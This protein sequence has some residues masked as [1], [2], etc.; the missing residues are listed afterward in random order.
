L[1]VNA[2]R[3]PGRGAGTSPA[4][5][6]AFA[7]RPRL[8]RLRD[9]LAGYRPPRNRWGEPAVF[10]FDPSRQAELD[11]AR[12]RDPKPPSDVTEL[13]AAELPHLLASVEVRRVAR[14][15]RGLREAAAT[16]VARLPVAKDLADLL[17][18]PDDETVL[19]LDPARRAGLRVFVRGI[20]DAARFQSLMLDAIA[21][22]VASRQSA[23]LLLL[24]PSAVRPDGSVPT[25][26]RGSDHWLWPQQPLASLPRIDGERVVLLAEAPFPM[27]WESEPRFQGMA[28][29]LR[30]ID[31]LNPF[32]VAERMGRLAGRP[33][34]VQVEGMHSEL[35]RAA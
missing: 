30:L 29:E 8:L 3:L 13:I 2:P 34:A 35:K 26:F 32:Q 12:S 17:A 33:V 20:A 4:P 7:A 28:A 15:V 14:A 1:I 16:F 19:V 25:G 21:D 10:F 24:R 27:D 11:A 18:V 9:A 5:D 23:P 31:V 22:H 6:P